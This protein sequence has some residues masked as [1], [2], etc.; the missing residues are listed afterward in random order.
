ME[1][2]PEAPEMPLPEPTGEGSRHSGR[3]VGIGAPEILDRAITMVEADGADALTMRSLANELDVATTTI[4][5][6]SGTA[7]S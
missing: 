2:N 1:H 7:L 6:Q 3:R 4:Y 5:W